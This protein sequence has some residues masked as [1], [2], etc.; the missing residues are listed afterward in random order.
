MAARRP[1]REGRCEVVSSQAGAAG[2]HLDLLASGEVAET[3]DRCGPAV[4]AAYRVEGAGELYLC[5]QCASR[6]WRALSVRGWIFWSLGVHAIA[7]QANPAPGCG[8]AED[9][10]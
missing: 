6:L 8:P 10:A 4:G 2:G 3:C 1:G 9:A 7:P 5:G